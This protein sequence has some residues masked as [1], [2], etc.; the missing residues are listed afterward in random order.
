MHI[1]FWWGN[2][3]ENVPLEDP[4]GDGRITLRVRL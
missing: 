4:E 2:L 1:E 3:L